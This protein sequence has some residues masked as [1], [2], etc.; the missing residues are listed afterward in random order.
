MPHCCSATWLPNRSL[1]DL[2]GPAGFG[3]ELTMDVQGQLRSTTRIGPSRNGAYV[4]TRSTICGLAWSPGLP[5]PNLRIRGVVSGAHRGQGCIRLA[6]P[7]HGGT[8]SVGDSNLQIALPG[9]P[10][11]PRFYR[12]PSPRRFPQVSPLRLQIILESVDYIGPRSQTASY[13]TQIMWWS[14]EAEVL[15]PS[16]IHR[17]CLNL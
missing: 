9:A 13:L 15:L 16:H 10:R 12:L 4:R 6:L 7:G 17:F 1:V 5:G 2:G 14:V 8:G 3:L 11:R